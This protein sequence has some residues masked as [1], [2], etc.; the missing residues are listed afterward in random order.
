MKQLK[1]P[2]LSLFAPA[3]AAAPGAQPAEPPTLPRPPAAEG[4]N[5]PPAPP[6]PVEATDPTPPAPSPDSAPLALAEVL[7][8]PAVY[9]GD[10]AELGYGYTLGW[11]GPARAGHAVR[12]WVC[13][14]DPS[15]YEWLRRAGEAVFVASEWLA[16]LYAVVND[17][18]GACLVD[19][20]GAKRTAP[21]RLLTLKTTLGDIGS[22]VV[23]GPRW[24]VGRVASEC[25]AQL[26]FF[27]SAADSC[28]ALSRI[29]SNIAGLDT[30]Q[31]MAAAGSRNDHVS[32]GN[33]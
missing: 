29:T 15:S 16:I 9:L 14:D 19:W 32:R 1:T 5:R 33:H 11:V 2:Q 23:P 3:A 25:S 6:A 20:V 31:L 30:L 12:W 24:S 26:C 8:Y 10:L 21:H 22:H 18:L 17:R 7:A 13:L 28:G 27:D 4:P